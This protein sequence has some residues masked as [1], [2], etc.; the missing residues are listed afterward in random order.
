MPPQIPAQ[1]FH[2][3]VMNTVAPRLYRGYDDVIRPS[4]QVLVRRP[5]HSQTT[6][7]ATVDVH[8]ERRKW[9]RRK[10]GRQKGR[11]IRGQGRKRKRL[12]LERRMLWRLL[13]GMRGS[14]GE[15]LHS[16]SSGHHEGAYGGGM[17]PLHGNDTLALRSRTLDG[18]F[19]SFSGP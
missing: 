14:G 5:Q 3:W 8:L 12:Q 1:H 18:G 7:V 15:V 6:V 11:H 13:R 17:R 10:R 16:L 4:L 2:Q 19:R 9:R